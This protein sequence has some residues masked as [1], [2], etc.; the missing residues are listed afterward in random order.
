M[1]VPLS[2]LSRHHPSGAHVSA[3]RI[4]TVIGHTRAVS[5]WRYL[6]P[7]WCAIGVALMGSA[8]FASPLWSQATRT[9]TGGGANNN[10]TT[11]GNWG[12]I[13]P[14][15]GD[16]LVFDAAGVAVRNAPANNF[17]NGTIFGTITVSAAGYTFTGSSQ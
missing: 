11:A 12:G 16:N 4:K 1:P 13:A 3:R 9:W 10:W 17:A 14:V 6:L 15:A 5:S 7:V 8:L 2:V